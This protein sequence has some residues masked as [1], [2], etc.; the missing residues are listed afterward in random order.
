MVD[1]LRPATRIA[2]DTEAD[3]LHS[4]A[5]KVCL[6]QATFG[7][8]NYIIDPLGELDLSGFLAA[9]ADKP[10][11]LHGAD[12]DLRLLRAS[13]GFR[14]QAPVFDTMLAA[15]LLGYEQIGQ[16]ALVERFVGVTL[17]KQGQKSDWSRR[18]LPERLLIYACNDTRYLETVADQLADGLEQKSRVGWHVESCVAVVDATAEDAEP[19][20]DEAWRVKHVSLLKPQERA[21]AREIWSWREEEARKTDRPPFKVLTNEAMLQLARWAAVNPDTAIEEG[22]RLPRNCT[23]NRLAALRA[24]LQTAHLVPKAQWPSRFRPRGLRF[25]GPDCRNEVDALREACARV[26]QTLGIDPSLIASRAKLTAIVRTQPKT[27][28]QIM[29]AGPLL[30]WQAT[31]MESAIRKISAPSLRAIQK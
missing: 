15:Q 10:I 7:E 4:Y 16:A 22:P 30:R 21:F 11:L 1:R 24:A 3:S 20:P 6:I 29:A 5:E 25:R 8:E 23:G 27:L 12:Y 18:P 19:D 28:E 2:L 26:A 13:F 9:L 31:L 17:S 14:P